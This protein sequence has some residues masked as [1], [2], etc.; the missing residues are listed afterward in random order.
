MWTL[1]PRVFI[2]EKLLVD[3]EVSYMNEAYKRFE[4]KAKI[5]KAER[6]LV[7]KSTIRVGFHAE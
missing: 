3:G 4:I 5:R 6:K 1:A 7:S 2:N